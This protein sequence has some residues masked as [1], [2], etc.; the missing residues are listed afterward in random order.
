MCTRAPGAGRRRGSSA[1]RGWCKP[2]AARHRAAAP[3]AASSLGASLGRLDG[4]LEG[5]EHLLLGFAEALVLLEV[6]GRV[7]ARDGRLVDGEGR[8]V[9]H[10]VEDDER[11]GRRLQDDV[12]PDLAVDGDLVDLADALGDDGVERDLRAGQLGLEPLL[13]LLAHALE[14]RGSVPDLDLLGRRGRGGGFDDGGHGSRELRELRW[15]RRLCSGRTR[16][17]AVAVALTG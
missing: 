15:L 1:P 10:G 2:H 7:P 9:D 13:G 8:A 11:H 12:V 4:G 5:G 6:H 16:E 3:R 17:L 14:S